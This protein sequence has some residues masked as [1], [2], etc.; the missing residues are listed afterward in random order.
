MARREL[1]RVVLLA[2]QALEPLA[3]CR[4][5]LA[6]DRKARGERVPAVREEQVGAAVEQSG[7]VEARQAAAGTATALAVDRDQERRQ[8]VS[9][10]ETGSHDADDPGVPCLGP[11]H[12]RAAARREL[13][14]EL[15]AR[16]LERARVELAPP[17]VVLFEALGARLRLVLLRCQEQPQA[18]LGVAHA[19]GGVDAR[20]QHERDLA[21]GDALLVQAR[22]LR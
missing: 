7:E 3:Q 19:A 9:F 20:C 6:L 14:L 4:K 1:L 16:L 21:A 5:L 12:D 10:D 22:D 2:H 11:Q 18:L 17:L 8:A 15:L 13:G